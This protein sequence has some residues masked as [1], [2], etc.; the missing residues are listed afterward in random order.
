MVR[1]PSVSGRGYMSRLLALGGSLSWYLGAEE[2]GCAVFGVP[3]RKEEPV[4]PCVMLRLFQRLWWNLSW[5]AWGRRGIKG[6][7]FFFFAAVWNGKPRSG[8]RR[9]LSSTYGRRL[10][11]TVSGGVWALPVWGGG[12]GAGEGMA[13]RMSAPSR[14]LRGGYLWLMQITEYCMGCFKGWHC[15]VGGHLQHEY[16]YEVEERDVRCGRG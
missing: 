14:G 3:T 2:C 1:A 11:E 5:V 13:S 12:V 7:C 16:S 9:P 15:R 4:C 6:G 8:P 10:A